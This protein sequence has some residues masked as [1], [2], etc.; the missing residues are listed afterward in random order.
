[1][2]INI[3]IK[4]ALLAVPVLL[5]GC[6]TF[7]QAHQMRSHVMQQAQQARL[8]A[9]QPIV[10][11][12]DTPYLMG[13]V[14]RVVKATPS[15]LKAPIVIRSGIPM[16]LQEIPGIFSTDT[17]IPVVMG[18]MGS[19]AT[20]K[21]ALPP[22]P[23]QPSS[24]PGGGEKRML[25]AAWTGSRAALLNAVAAHFACWWKYTDGQVVL[26]RR[27][28][29]TFLVPAFA[30]KT[31]SSNS[32]T[33]SSGGTTGGS[34]G[35]MSGGGAAGGSAMGGSAMGGGSSGSSSGGSQG[36]GSV[37]IVNTT[38]VDVWSNLAKEAKTVAEGAT[39]FTN[40]ALGSITVT[41][42]PVQVSAVASW[43][44][45]MT[46]QMGMQVALVVHVYQVTVNNEQNYG[47]NPS[48]AFQSVGSQYGMSF[49]GAPAPQ[50]A[51]GTAPMSLSAGILSGPFSGTKVVAQALATLG[52]ITASY[53]Y[54][55]VT[56]N[57]Q[58]VSIQSA[59]NTGYLAETSPSIIS[60]G[61]AT[62]GGLQPGQVTAGFTALLTP[63]IIGNNIFLSMNMTISSLIKLQSFSSGGQTIYTPD[64]DSFSSPQ[65]VKLKS[66]DT[67][68]LSE[69]KQDTSSTTHNG[70]G[71]PYMPIL[72]GGADASTSHQMI[73]ITVSARIL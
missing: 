63:R 51:S 54:P 71:S 21:V 27:E 35:S 18:D 5:S 16:T 34:S 50:P 2:R 1:M 59:Q 42:T 12:V 36:S 8:P 61:V 13:S 32:I 15:I 17:G 9:S 6:A 25:L 20:S 40:P 56:L 47:F 64:T 48:V 11:T 29:R 53:S 60:N 14:V 55:N 28:T 49:S 22:L 70:V 38:H 24:M 72:G 10:Q 7:H 44:H 58:P 30:V 3:A 46:R 66:G 37:S 39:V 23:G 43:V 57:D 19:S 31:Q 69:L 65:M 33:A 4:M 62:T 67:L 41:G 26:Y 45:G 73:V 68:V 52:N